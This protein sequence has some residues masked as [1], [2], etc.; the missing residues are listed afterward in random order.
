MA[1]LTELKKEFLKLSTEQVLEPSKDK[2]ERLAQLDK[3]IIELSK[4]K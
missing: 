4:N 1:T 3:Q 2:L